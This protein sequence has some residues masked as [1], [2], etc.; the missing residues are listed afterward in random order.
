MKLFTSDGARFQL[1]MRA[2]RLHSLTKSIS[3]ISD[4]A[5]LQRSNLTYGTD[6]VSQPATMDSK[7]EKSMGR[8]QSGKENCKSVEKMTELI[9]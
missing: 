7:N 2:V 4:L 5:V 9:V 1:P 3:I 6:H 8:K